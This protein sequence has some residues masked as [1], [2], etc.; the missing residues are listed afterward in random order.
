MAELLRVQ[1][2]L[3]AAAFFSSDFFFASFLSGQQSKIAAAVSEIREL[4][5]W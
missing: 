1:H 3:V 2:G 5:W 4:L